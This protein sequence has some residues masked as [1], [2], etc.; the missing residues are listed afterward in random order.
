VALLKW[1]PEATAP[2]LDLVSSVKGWA[3]PAIGRHADQVDCGRVAA[4]G[5]EYLAELEPLAAE[6]PM[7]WIH[8]DIH[9]GNMLFAG[10][11]LTG[12]LDFEM[13]RRGPRLFDP[14]Y[15]ATS[16]LIGGWQDPGNRM[17]WPGLL[18]ELIAGYEETIPLTEPE[19]KAIFSVLSGIE[20]I[21]MAF[22][23]EHEQYGPARCNQDVLSWLHDSRARIGV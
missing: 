3:L 13:V 2:G 16:I 4:M 22:C 9:P 12:I 6:L 8:R 21:F 20:F 1:R 15:C 14:C 7:Q 19:R 10:D 23:L 17:A 18:K 5:D 11:E